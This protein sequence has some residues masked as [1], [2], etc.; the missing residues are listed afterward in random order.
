MKKTKLNNQR[1]IKYG[2]ESVD[3]T[4]QCCNYLLENNF[5]ENDKL[6]NLNLL[7]HILVNFSIIKLV[8]W[9]IDLDTIG[10]HNFDNLEEI[11]TALNEV[12]PTKEE[13]ESYFSQYVHCILYFFETINKQ[14]EI[15]WIRKNESNFEIN[16]IFENNILNEINTGINISI[17]E[18]PTQLLEK[19]KSLYQEKEKNPVLKK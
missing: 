12:I 19:F 13:K 8:E 2:S 5:F 6:T 7:E 14:H 16:Y 4:K 18:I 11:L 10:V 17:H 15:K 1:I 9:N 3:I